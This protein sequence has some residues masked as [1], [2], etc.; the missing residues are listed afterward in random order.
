MLTATLPNGQTITRKTWHD[1]KFVV[2][3][4][5]KSGD[6]WQL[7]GEE[8]SAL[9]WTTRKDLAEKAVKHF[10]A[11]NAWTEIAIIPVNQSS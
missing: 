11:W 3:G 10:S 6:Y 4:K 1:Y 5:N 2:V 9:R 7:R 8:W